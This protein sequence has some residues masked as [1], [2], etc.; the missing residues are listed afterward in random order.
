M[1]DQ[2][3]NDLCG[4]PPLRSAEPGPP[5]R[6]DRQADGKWKSASRV[7]RPGGGYGRPQ[8]G[9]RCTLTGSLTGVSG[10]M[11]GHGHGFDRD[12]WVSGNQFSFTLS[13]TLGGNPPTSSS[14]E[15][16]KASK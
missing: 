2:G 16:S 5:R 11:V 8:H 4:R 12:G 7:R 3:E 1:K 6:P 14:A 15:R 10:A 13:L 9:I